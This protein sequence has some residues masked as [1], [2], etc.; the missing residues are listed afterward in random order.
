MLNYWSITAYLA[1]KLGISL[2]GKMPA[3]QDLTISG[4]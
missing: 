4:L 3:L 1:S 2:A